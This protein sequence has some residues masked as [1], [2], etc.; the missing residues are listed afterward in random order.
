MKKKKS[1]SITSDHIFDVFNTIILVLFSLIVLYP[2][3][4]V[5]SSSFSSPNALMAGKV[6]FAP[7]DPTLD[8]YRAVIHH[9]DIWTG[10]KN[11][12]FYTVVGTIINLVV[13]VLAAYPLSRKDFTSRGWISLFFAFTMWFG[14]GLIPTFLLIK[15][16]GLYNT[17]AVMLIPLAMNV[18]NMIIVRTYF[19]SNISD[20]LLEVAK[21]DGCSDIRFLTKIVVP[22][23]KPVLAVVA[24]Y[25]A[26]ANWNIYAHAYIYINKP[27]LQPI[28]VVLRDILLLNST[29][30]IS[31]DVTKMGKSEQLSELLKYSLVVVASIPMILIY[32]FVQKHFVKGIMVGSVK[33]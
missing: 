7:I 3:I 10:I 32:P 31:V 16:M 30:E 11:S 17:R 21:I 19:Q 14:G 15:D 6:L 23:S 9:P 12:I 4:V 18:W 13:S 24:L 8:G 20:D 22:L 5:V 26:V 2:I 1:F 33:G 28:Q 29:Q 25:Y 27:E